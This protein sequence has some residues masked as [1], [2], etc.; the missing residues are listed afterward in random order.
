MI[1]IRENQATTLRRRYS[2]AFRAE[3]LA[4]CQV[5][6][7]PVA[8]IARNH[9]F[10]ANRV[11]R[12]MKGHARV[13][14]GSALN[15]HAKLPGFI[16]VALPAPV[17]TVKHP[18]IAISILHSCGTIV[19]R[20]TAQQVSLCGALLQE[21]LVQAVRSGRLPSSVGRENSLICSSKR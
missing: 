4:Q 13:A 17:A 5:A 1:Q 21:W 8:N 14:T 6:G 15:S 16:P 18:P 10:N 9:H 12:C 11:H 19:V 7:T 20:C 2:R 3:I